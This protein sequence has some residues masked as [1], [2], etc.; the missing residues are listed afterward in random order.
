M[1]FPFVDRVPPCWTWHISTSL[2]LGRLKPRAR[3]EAWCRAVFPLVCLQQECYLPLFFA[4]V[5]WER[6]SANL[7][8]PFCPCLL[9]L[10]P[11]HLPRV[12]QF[13]LWSVHGCKQ[14]AQSSV[15]L[16][17][18][19]A[20]N[21]GG[22][23]GGEKAPST[24]GAS[25]CTRVPKCPVQTGLSCPGRQGLRVACPPGSGPSRRGMDHLWCL[26]G[27]GDPTEAG[28]QSTGHSPST[29]WARNQ[30]APHLPEHCVLET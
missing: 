27:Q 2:A 21:L 1:L 5:L 13:F 17:L 6:L 3:S 22:C 28:L 24:L 4:A 30:N 7:Q 14:F 29:L 18:Q 25:C 26:E 20:G 9:R 12:G 15:R 19:G 23:L 8:A 10:F 16:C 11:A